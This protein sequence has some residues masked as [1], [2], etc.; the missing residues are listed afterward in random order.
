MKICKKC[1]SKHKDSI[2][3]CPTCKSIVYTIQSKNS[4]LNSLKS[5]DCITLVKDKKP[6]CI[7]DKPP[8]S[9]WNPPAPVTILS[10]IY[11]I[12]Y[13]DLKYDRGNHFIKFTRVA[14]QLKDKTYCCAVC[15][16]Y[17]SLDNSCLRKNCIVVSKK[18]IC[19]SFEPKPE[20]RLNIRSDAYMELIEKNNK[21]GKRMNKKKNKKNNKKPIINPLKPKYT[22][23]HQYLK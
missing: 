14:S 21:K 17:M 6:N 22:S 23:F 16:Y 7:N 15:S 19:K 2:N 1:N 10:K 5:K 3:F 11:N 18:C 13:Y 4:D 12:R 8:Y 9:D 20:Y